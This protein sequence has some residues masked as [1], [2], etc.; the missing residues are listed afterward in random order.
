MVD[1]NDDKQREVSKRWLRDKE[2][3]SHMNLLALLQQ[4]KSLDFK[5][6]F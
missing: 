5:N 1:D 6:G 4:E 2:N 3:Y